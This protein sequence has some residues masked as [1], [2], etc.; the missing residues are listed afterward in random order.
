MLD[1]SDVYH[2]TYEDN[3]YHD[4]L[5]DARVKYDCEMKKEELIIS[6]KK[7]LNNNSCFYDELKS[8]VLNN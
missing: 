2:E 4:L 7:K 1:G 8:F 3:S 6:I 5:M